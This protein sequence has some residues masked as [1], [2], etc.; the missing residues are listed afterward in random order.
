MAP[1]RVSGMPPRPG[2]RAASRVRCGAH[3]GP[4]RS[5]ASSP[6]TT[7]AILVPTDSRSSTS[8]RDSSRRGAELAHW[9]RPASARTARRRLGGTDTKPLATTA[10][11]GV[12][13]SLAV[14]PRSGRILGGPACRYSFTPRSPAGQ[15]SQPSKN[16]TEHAHLQAR[17]CG[18]RRSARASRSL[19]AARPIGQ[20]P[21]RDAARARTRTPSA[22][23][24]AARW[25]PSPGG[26]PAVR[27][28]G[29][30]RSPSRASSPTSHPRPTRSSARIRLTDHPSATW[31][32]R[33]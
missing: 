19:V 3:T 16:Q 14:L 1:V 18:L 9:A 11:A 29:Q 17:C 26:I 5:P 2:P 4:S 6:P 27:P 32:A 21:T 20:V 33:R 8:V 10:A 7:A 12:G 25:R 15:A 28:S 22:G 30:G 24:P 23:L 31:R 13:S